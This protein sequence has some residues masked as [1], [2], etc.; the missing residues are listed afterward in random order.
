VVSNFVVAALAR[1]PLTVYGDG[2]QTRS[3]CY[4]DDQIRGLLALLDSDHVGPVNIGSPEER[5]VLDLAE[6]VLKAV[7]SGSRIVFAPLPTDDPVQRR[8]DIRLAGEVLGWEPVVAL[9][10]GLARTVAWFAAGEEPRF[11]GLSLG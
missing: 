1:E 11:G 6:A 7:G 8:P 9:E 5:R 2:S 10:E 3:F 4:V